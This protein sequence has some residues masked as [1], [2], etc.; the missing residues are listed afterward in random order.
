MHDLLNNL[1]Y[2]FNVFL[3]YFNFFLISPTVVTILLFLFV[4][5]WVCSEPLRSAALR[6]L[7]RRTRSYK[8]CT[9][10][11]LSTETNG[12]ATT[13]ASTSDHWKE[14]DYWYHVC[15]CAR[16]CV[17]LCVCVCLCYFLC[18]GRI[19]MKL[20][21]QIDL[22]SLCTD[23]LEHFMHR[24]TWTLWAQMVLALCAQIHLCTLC[25]DEPEHYVHRKTSALCAQIDLSTLFMWLIVIDLRQSQTKQ[26]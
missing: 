6:P 22:S 17:R 24:W 19:L 16:A 8:S 10:Q 9:K 25:T 4:S 23:K 2:L 21:V 20:S 12:A 7:G 3:L 5:S 11:V 15:V 13:S 14:S 26:E 18:V 1:N